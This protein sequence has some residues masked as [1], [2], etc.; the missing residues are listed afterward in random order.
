MSQRSRRNR[1]RSFWSIFYRSDSQ[2]SR[3]TGSRS[4]SVG[5]GDVKPRKSLKDRWKQFKKRW[6]AARNTELAGSRNSKTG[7]F[8]FKKIQRILSA[9]SFD[10]NSQENRR[11][12]SVKANKY[13]KFIKTHGAS[14]LLIIPC[15]IAMF[16]VTFIVVSSLPQNS[17]INSAYKSQF[18]SAIAEKNN[19]FAEL[20]V[21][22]QAGKT[23][24]PDKSLLIDYA[25]FHEMAGHP[26]ITR[27]IYQTLAFDT[28][29]NYGVATLFIAKQYL[30]ENNQTNEMK[31]TLERLLLRAMADK[32]VES[33]V[34][35]E[36]GT[37]YRK[38]GRL[39]DAAR[40]LDPL[41]EN[42]SGAI[43]IALVWND[44]KKQGE[45]EILLSPFIAKWQQLLQKPETSTEFEM[46]LMGLAM[47]KNEKPVIETL[48]KSSATIPLARRK[49]L[50]EFSMKCWMERLLREGPRAYAEILTLINTYQPELPC[51]IIWF[52]PLMQI[53]ISDTPL[54]RDAL[55]LCDNLIQKSACSADDLLEVLREI[56]SWGDL[57]QAEKIADI[58]FEKYPDQVTTILKSATE[59]DQIEPKNTRKALEILDR[60]VRQ[61]PENANAREAR[62]ELRLQ[63]NLVSEAITDLLATSS[64]N[65]I[66]PEFHLRL[67]SLYRK[68]KDE[69]N[70]L[71]HEELAS[72]LTLPES[73]KKSK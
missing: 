31:L 7:G 59:F 4:Y 11:K 39:N 15:L 55:S 52:R 45:I 62:A 41:R 13:L 46:A 66:Y 54:N 30:S 6:N 47:T 32:T 57:K 71:I 68:I 58:I 43:A 60:L 25:R 28:A 22:K 1:K 3:I 19:R 44:Q 67:A 5:S 21:K 33:D 10:A 12:K 38:N 48:N 40:I 26:F 42:E 9:N 18:D 29:N 65:Q 17:S 2:G 73:P 27:Q 72:E 56:K 20:L 61:K 69:A 36:L 64:V 37:F 70:A 14:V 53:G 24:F 16:Y 35:L 63:N 8:S 23:S 50:T 51:S 49:E 34:R